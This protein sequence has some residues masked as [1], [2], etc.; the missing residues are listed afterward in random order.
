M[1]FYQETQHYP[2]NSTKNQRIH[3]REDST[4]DNDIHSKEGC[5]EWKKTK[6]IDW[7]ESQVNLS[8]SKVM[9]MCTYSATNI[10]KG[11]LMGKTYVATS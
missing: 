2:E 7:S 9:L 11:P 10:T 3:R 4:V 6:P 1:F 5:V 8:Q